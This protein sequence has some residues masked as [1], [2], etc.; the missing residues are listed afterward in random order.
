MSTPT[1][2]DGSLTLETL[3]Q[4]LDDHFQSNARDITRFAGTGYSFEDW[5]NWE[6]FSAFT[7]RGLKCFPKPAYKT[8]FA[9]TGVKT[10]G[11]VLVTTEGSN[12][13]L[14]ETSLVHGYTKDKWRTKIIADRDKLLLADGGGVSKV[15]LVVLCSDCEQNLQEAWDYWFEA[16]PFWGLPDAQR[17]FT[18]GE[19]GEVC[20]L[21]WQIS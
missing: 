15:Q 21:F 1:L 7:A 11:D 10:L 19:Q 13:W 18:D 5:L 9:Q 8:H 3:A 2:S 12:A 16:M 4:I 14:V 20:L 6:M 17:S